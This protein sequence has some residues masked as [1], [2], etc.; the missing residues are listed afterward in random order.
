MMSYEEFK[1]CITADAKE[2]FPDAEVQIRNYEKSNASCEAL[3]I[4]KS[5]SLEVC[6]DLNEAYASYLMAQDGDDAYFEILESIRNAVGNANPGFSREGLMELMRDF[7]NIKD[8]LTLK[9]VETNRNKGVLQ[10]IVHRNILDMSL[11][12]YVSV[13]PGYTTAVTNELLSSWGIVEED[14]YRVAIANAAKNNPLVI[15]DLGEYLTNLGYP[16]LEKTNL[17]FATNKEM[18]Y[19]ASV[20]CYPGALKSISEKLDGSF[21]IMPSSIHEILCHP[22][23][24]VSAEE[25]RNLV[26]QV[27]QETVAEEEQL[28]NSVYYYNAENGELSI[29]AA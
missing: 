5:D 8:R 24:D 6:T 9:L 29:A 3:G 27:N 11:M 21:Y 25:L 15:N 4:R 26:Q 19:G 12:Y 17:I 1:I 23:A 28:T 2:A 18:C 13:A 16:I 10:K 22:D 20:I 14:L 7:D